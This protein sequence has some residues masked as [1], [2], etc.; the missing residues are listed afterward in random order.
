MRYFRRLTSEAPEGRTNAVIMGRKTWASIPDRFRPL[1]G[2]LNI[3]LSRRP[4]L[5]LPDGVLHAHD[6]D[7][8]LSLAYNASGGH[9]CFVIG[10]GTIYRLALLHPDC[11]RLYLTRVD[12]TYSCDTFL[13]SLDDRFE[14]ESRSAPQADGDVT[15]EFRVYRNSEAGTWPS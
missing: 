8:A 1:R 14:L 13:P 5:E 6:F 15:Y 9:R 10:G 11:A 4:T 3:V 12:A 2:R 7:D